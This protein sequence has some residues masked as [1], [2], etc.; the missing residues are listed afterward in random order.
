MSG[1]SER[2]KVCS[3]IKGGGDVAK[4]SEK[5][6]DFFKMSLKCLKGIAMQKMEKKLNCC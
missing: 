5:K 1:K 3:E 4:K 6:S 2:E